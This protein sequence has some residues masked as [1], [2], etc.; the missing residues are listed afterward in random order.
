MKRIDFVKNV[1]LFAEKTGF[2]IKYKN[3]INNEGFP[4]TNKSPNVNVWCKSI[5]ENKKDKSKYNENSFLSFVMDSVDE[6][7]DGRYNDFSLVF[8]PQ[9]DDKD[10]VVKCLFGLVVGTNGFSLDSELASLPYPRRFFLKMKEYGAT[11]YFKQN[12]ENIEYT[13]KHLTNEIKTFQQIK[14][15]GDYI[16]IAEI[17]EDLEKA[18]YYENGNIKLPK[19][20]A[21]WIL[22]YALFRDWQKEDEIHEL[23]NEI[24]DS[25]KITPKNTND[26]EIQAI[27]GILKTDKYVILQGAPGVGKTYT[28]SRLS[29]KEYFKETVFEQFHAETTYSDFIYGIIPD[30]S[31][32]QLAYKNKKG[33]LYI[34]IE[35]ALSASGKGWDELKEKLK[36]DE[37][38]TYNKDNAV[39]LIIDEINRANLANVLGPV[40]YLFERSSQH[41]S[42]LIQIGDKE[43]CRLPENLYVVGTMNT[44][45][46][47][48]A[49][50]D[51][52]LRRRFTWISLA[53]KDLSNEDQLDKPYNYFNIK[54]FDWFK[55]TFERYASDE[56]LNLQPG[57][58][59][60]LTKKPADRTDR[61]MYSMMKYKLMPL[62]K[63]YLNEGYLLRAKDE[64]SMY[65]F[66]EWN[67]NLYE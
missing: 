51:F 14:K 60:F 46:R 2:K 31:K 6:N 17:E 49:V 34:A 30:T 23:L 28:T 19:S 54:E 7:D 44:A 20:I 25:Q 35:K 45:D 47:S 48:L 64:F 26:N 15:Y 39:L 37:S 59:Y 56:E 10:N 55:K 38:Y 18:E 32:Q 53:P 57:Q 62:I 4:K 3:E 33:I 21:R 65:F 40:F 24:Y 5:V 22:F 36:D 11:L 42:N 61:P 50:V 41:R 16:Q 58:E 52:A 12:V 67:L 9:I 27:L 29:Q 66:N 1:L 8:F 63:E 43:I 13:I